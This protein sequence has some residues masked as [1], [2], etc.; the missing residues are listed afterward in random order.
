LLDNDR[1][2]NNDM[3]S[4]AREQVLSKNIYAAATE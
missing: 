3:T 2:K 1:E 4:A